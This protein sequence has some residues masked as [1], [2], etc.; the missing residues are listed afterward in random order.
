MNVNRKLNSC[1]VLF[2]AIAI[3]ANVSN[4]AFAINILDAEVK[5]IL[6]QQ[7]TNA[8]RIYNGEFKGNY[9]YH[10]DYGRAKGLPKE[11]IREYETSYEGIKVIGPPGGY[12]RY[13]KLDNPLKINGEKRTLGFDE[14]QKRVWNYFD[15]ERRLEYQPDANFAQ[16]LKKK[17]TGT[18]NWMEVHPLFYGVTYQ[19][20]T[21]KELSEH[22]GNVKILRDTKESNIVSLQFSGTDP[23][24]TSVKIVVSMD[25]DKDLFISGYEVYRS[26][27]GE[28]EY[29]LVEE[30]DITSVEGP[31]GL[32]YPGEVTHDYFQQVKDESGKKSS[33]K[34]INR[35]M[36]FE[37][38]ELNNPEMTPEVLQ[39]QMT[40][41][42]TVIDQ[43]LGFK[44]KIGYSLDLAQEQL[45]NL[46]EGLSGNLETGEEVDAMQSQPVPAEITGESFTAKSNQK[47]HD[48]KA[49]AFVTRKDRIVRFMLL[50]IAAILGVIVA[51]GLS[52]KYLGEK[53]ND[54][55]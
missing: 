3:L 50:A 35:K 25:T 23:F 12:I 51:I 54:K 55:S 26:V 9:S 46:T 43:E 11:E 22:L 27:P 17:D 31:H 1:I 7:A 24:E 30:V 13:D 4:H 5:A 2:L 28:E 10:M 32:W 16:L 42:T 38:F 19:G 36:E 34:I 45:E 41:G 53:Q 48:I 37:A 29:F 21:L 18:A 6:N 52:R 44:Y 49:I 20:R 40:E 47:K 15:T 33:R 14:E 8:S 39:F